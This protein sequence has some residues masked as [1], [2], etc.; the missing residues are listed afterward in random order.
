MPLQHCH[1]V[2]C[3]D[4]CHQAYAYPFAY[5][6]V[7]GVFLLH[8]NSGESWDLIHLCWGWISWE[9]GSGGEGEG[10][11]DE[12]EKDKIDKILLKLFFLTIKI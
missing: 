7:F 1:F 11:K 3:V 10:V 12:K 9:E 5:S 8:L 2:S 4:N 6:F